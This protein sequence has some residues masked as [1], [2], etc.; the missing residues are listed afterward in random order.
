MKATALLLLLSTIV[1]SAQEPETS[2]SDFR[3]QIRSTEF[4]RYILQATNAVQ[5]RQRL[6]ITASG[7]SGEQVFTLGTLSELIG[8]DGSTYAQSNTVVVVTS[9]RE[10]I[11][12]GGGMRWNLVTNSIAATNGIDTF[13]AVGGGRWIGNWDGDVRA[14]GPPDNGDEDAQP[15]LQSALDLARTRR[16]ALIAAPDS[17]YMMRTSL[18]LRTGARLYG[19]GSSSVFIKGWGEPDVGST[20]PSGAII[21]EGADYPSWG[22]TMQI[23][24]SNIVLRD[25]RIEG[26]LPFAGPLLY[27]DSTENVSISGLEIIG[28][29]NQQDF[30][31]WVRGNK[32][33]ASDGLVWNVGRIFQDGIHLGGGDD[34]KFDNWDVY[35]GDDA[36]VVGTSRDQPLS[37]FV[38]N[39]IT[40]GS[41]HGH[42]LRVAQNTNTVV[43]AGQS[44]SSVIQ[45]GVFSDLNMFGGWERN[46]LVLFEEDWDGWDEGVPSPGAFRYITIADSTFTAGPIDGHDGLNPWGIRILGGHVITLD[47][48]TIIDPIRS[49]IS[50]EGVQGL[51]LDN[52]KVPNGIQSDSTAYRAA[53]F[54]SQTYGVP[55]RDIQIS[56]GLY[57]VDSEGQSAIV[58]RYT[59]TAKVIGTTIRGVGV[60]GGN[61]ISFSEGTT[62]GTAMANHIFSMTNGVVVSSADIITSIGNQFSNVVNQYSGTP[63]RMLR[64]D[65][66]F[67][68]SNPDLGYL[69]KL[70]RNA[71]S[72]E[73]GWY[74]GRFNLNAGFGGLQVAD[75]NTD[76]TAKTFKL[77]IPHY[78]SG[79]IGSPVLLRAR[80][81]INDTIANWGF[82]DSQQ[83][84]IT[85][86]RFGVGTNENH[87]TGIEVMRIQDDGVRISAGG[88][89]D[90]PD[91][92]AA[93]EIHS[94]TKGFLPPRLTQTQIDAMTPALGLVV[95]NLTTTNLQLRIPGAW[96]DLYSAPS[97]GGGS[98][99]FYLTDSDQ[100]L[101]TLTGGTN[102]SGRIAELQV[103]GTNIAAGAIT[104]SKL[105]SSSVGP[106]QLANTAV[107]AGTYGQGMSNAVFTADSDG[108]LTFASNAPPRMVFFESTL[109]FGE[110]LDGASESINISAP[111]VVADDYPL[112]SFPY[113]ANDSDLPLF[114]WCITD[115]LTVTVINRT[116]GTVNPDAETVRAIVFKDP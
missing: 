80:A 61:A 56:G 31:V 1:A 59:D 109:N 37:D 102:F 85:Q 41:T 5:A 39:G 52:V 115:N 25:F 83:P 15:I 70:T 53:D 55:N 72:A 94:T 42:A 36:L 19:Y 26:Q 90:A 10:Q 14:A 107:T 32:I 63:T 88:L 13:E 77:A 113:L 76:D 82:S 96:V 20:K 47:N 48:V 111:G 2:D 49:G 29:T 24:S 73:F 62:N 99:G 17:L 81:E 97:G 116:G 44:I 110:L 79:S 9:G 18:V 66:A 54:A 40:G 46:G 87:V 105:G 4:T 57:E 67:E 16:I 28:T 12:D 74:G 92:S 68:V 27:I 103:Q 21:T 8:F 78:D 35:A 60:L 50:A 95:F 108:R 38:F 6:G 89:P 84:A 33:R 22:E 100:F 69:L 34:I 23:L 65:N 98:G 114:V 30:A 104:S 101:W 7:G 86:H 51:Y 75:N 93:L 112:L 43:W 71:N 11:G 45:R 91:A 58:F 64:A 3:R 106:T